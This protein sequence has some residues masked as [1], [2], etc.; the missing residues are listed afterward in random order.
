MRDHVD[1]N[2]IAGAQYVGVHFAT[3]GVYTGE[4]L[5]PR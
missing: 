3:L 5:L 4:A 1:S 2:D